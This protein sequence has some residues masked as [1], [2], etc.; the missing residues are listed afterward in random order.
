[1][2]RLVPR[3]HLSAS[4]P[5]LFKAAGRSDLGYV[6]SHSF[7]PFSPVFFKVV[8]TD[9]AH[10]LST[11]VTPASSAWVFPPKL[12]MD[13][14]QVP[15]AMG[16]HISTSSHDTNSWHTHDIKLDWRHPLMIPVYVALGSVLTLSIRALASFAPFF[17]TRLSSG[18]RDSGP[19]LVDEH[20]PTGGLLSR[21]KET[22]RKHGGLTIYLF[23]VA[24]FI[25]VVILLG[26]SVATILQDDKQGQ[27][28]GS[29]DSLPTTVQYDAPSKV[30]NWLDF[31]LYSTYIYTLLLANLSLNA[32]LKWNDMASTHLTTILLA[33]FAVYAYRDIWPLATYTLVP[34]DQ[35]EGLILWAKIVVLGFAAVIVPIFS[36]RQYIPYDP[37]EPTKDPSPE[38][39]ASI[40]SLWTYTFMDPIVFMGYR[41]RHLPFDLLPPLAD[42]DHAKNLAGKSFKHLDVFSGSP[43]SYLL[44]GLIKVFAREYIVMTVVLIVKVVSAFFAPIGI[45]QVLLYLENNGEGA[46]VRPWVWIAWLLIGPLISTLALQFYSFVGSNVLIR[47]EAIITQLV[48]EHSLRMRMKAE[49]NEDKTT[50]SPNG[51]AGKPPA[52]KGGNTLGKINNL[53]T[54][55]LSNLTDGRDIL[56]LV[57]NVPLQLAMCTWFLYTYLGW[58]TFVGMGTMILLFPI[59]GKVTQMM[60]KVQKEAMKK[61]DAR[62]QTVTET[63]SVIRMVK[64]FAWERK[65]GDIVAEK[66]DAELKILIKRQLLHLVNANVN[67]VLPLI[68]MIATFG[69]YTGIMKQSLKP[70]VVFSSLAVFDMMKEQ[71][72]YMI[73]FLPW[74]IQ[75]KVAADRV[76]DFLKNTELLDEFAGPVDK[77]SALPDPSLLPGA[78]N[79]IGIKDAVFTWSN[80]D[81]V[82]GTVTP[83]T[84]RFVLHIDDEV[85][86]K[87]GGIN[88]IVGP[89]GSGKTSLLMALLGEMHFVPQ[90]PGSWRYLPRDGGVAYAAQESWVQNETIRENILFGAPYEESRYEKG[91]DFP[92]IKSVPPSLTVYLVIYQCGLTRDIGLFEAGDRTEVGEK[93]L[94]LSGGQKA[95]ITLARAVYSSAEIL[96]LDDV[97]AAL[98]VHTAQWAVDKCFKGD[99]IKGRT[100]LLVTHNL[101]LTTRIADYVVALSLDGKISSRGTLS[102]ALAKDETLQAELAEEIHEIE[103][104]NKEIDSKSPGTVPK[105]AEGKLIATE[106]V[107]EGHVSW[108]S[109]KLFLGSLGGSLFWIVF[110]GGMILS[111]A[112]SSVQTW[113]LGYWAEQ[114]DLH[115]NPADV[116]ISFYFT[117]YALL[118]LANVLFYTIGYGVFAYGSIRAS[119]SIHKK[120]IQTVLGTTLRWLDTTPTSRVIAR[121][122]QDVRALDGPIASSFAWVVELALTMGIKL[123]S[124]V[125]FTPAFLIPGLIVALVGGWCGRIYMKAQLAVKREKSNARAPVL[126]HFG[127][128]ITGLTSIR[129][130]NAQLTF[131]RE[132]YIR[133]DRYSRAAR[134]MINMNRWINLRLDVLGGLFT[135]ALAAYLVYGPGRKDVLPSDTGFS[136]TMA[137]G[138]SGLIMWWVRFYN[139]FEV[140]GNSLERIQAYLEIEQEP[141]ATKEGTPPAYWPASGDLKV[142]H[143]S[144]RYSGD[145][146]EVL[147]DLSFHVKSGERVGIVGRTGS[148]KSSL[149]L[150]L[151]RCILTEGNVYYD[152]L[153][154]N[155]INLDDLRSNVTIIPQM[156][157]LLTGTLRENLDPF[158]QYDDQALNAALRA[159]GLFSL[160]ADNDDNRITLDSAIAGGG[161]NLSVGQRQILALARA[162]VRGSKLLILDE[163]TSAIDYETDTV[164]QSSLRTELK[165]DVTVLTVAHRLQ[166]IMDADKIMVLDAG[167]IVEYDTPSELLKKKDGMFRSMVDQ[168]GDKDAL[169]AV[170]RAVGSK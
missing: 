73:F 77:V 137:V 96:L 166:T 85:L 42:Y 26:L 118:L 168:S 115:K 30:I 99:L 10:G 82:D 112:A 37:K 68:T 113:F 102:D 97:L 16:G 130:Y 134:T 106:E 150:S 51:A 133:I 122:T 110:V 109:L 95:R 43:K 125:L 158:G 36:P 58:S 163:A 164:I 47:V 154:T 70:S 103:Q 91:E 15:L 105:Q 152:G 3:A 24:R 62:V 53:V 19:E 108:E 144:A 72:R 32:T 155:S 69:T 124:I 39:T 162:I 100:I 101:A 78:E 89:T 141:K 165:R 149:T 49:T 79:I 87:R 161:G 31:A 54:T 35:H 66:R 27:S 44:S 60:Q 145:G 67:F 5:F 132:S 8:L 13:S 146:P 116:H 59:P 11:P 159:A 75:A 6:P 131:C 71:L 83:S 33:T 25:S 76:D 9:F 135:S 1:M 17:K 48:L 40:F 64:L 55:D 142:E 169:Y 84:R 93:G 18:E 98:D 50:D 88:L 29:D 167:H 22:A 74:M 127:A 21:F 120:F 119:R 160:H 170:V 86:F 61:T 45:N 80:E 104:D 136:L 90:S 94:T 34:A 57:V 114:Y 63:M 46:T 156:P 123:L 128:A 138:F 143:L 117:I 153:L 7:Y 81:A 92:A 65:L 4:L 2:T 140:Q 107:A 20:G 14:G 121:C 139:D 151:L 28:D 126:G 23:K 41:M 52:A 56:L 147:H 111:N 157:E 148:G 129:A 12:E 38:Q